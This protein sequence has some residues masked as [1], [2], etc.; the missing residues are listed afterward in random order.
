[1]VEPPRLC[2]R[3][4]RQKLRYNPLRRLMPIR[5]PSLRE[6]IRK[7]LALP[8]RLRYRLQPEIPD[9]PGAKALPMFYP[10]GIE[11]APVRV[12]TDEEI[13]LGFQIH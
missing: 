1:M 5:T 13:I 4:I 7:I 12:N 3:M 2:H 6:Q 8:S 9:K 10:H 11:R